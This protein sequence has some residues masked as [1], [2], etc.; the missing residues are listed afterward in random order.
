MTLIAAI[1]LLNVLC[2]LSDQA[3]SVPHATAIEK[4]ILE[5]R[6]QLYSG[7][8]T[9][10]AT[11]WTIGNEKKRDRKAVIWFDRQK[12]RRDDSLDS[13]RKETVFSD[14]SLIYWVQGEPVWVT[15][16]K[17]KKLSERRKVTD[18]R[19]LGTAPASERNLVHSRLTLYISRGDRTHVNVK[20]EKFKE[21]DC[22]VI[23]YETSRGGKI[24]VWSGIDYGNAPVKIETKN[25]VAGVRI[26]QYVESHLFFVPGGK[27]WF[28][29]TC[30]WRRYENDI[31]VA[32]EDLKV[33]EA[34]FNIDVDPRVFTLEALD[35][36]KDTK[37]MLDKKADSGK[38]LERVVWD[39]DKLIPELPG[40][41]TLRRSRVN[42]AFI[43]LGVAF[44]LLVVYFARKYLKGSTGRLKK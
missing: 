39:G 12:I 17:E 15:S 32:E 44:G 18:P 36:P 13:G 14:D 2:A 26:Y 35:L 5:Q 16:L 19:L 42:R 38:A 30:L 40:D 9:L 7:H 8:L 34:Q 3:S 22:W 20:R 21:Y 43:A 33:F 11:L 25:D 27:L 4:P 29:K 10:G 6:R 23:S 41:I 31:L 24:R 28:P 37:V 1:Q